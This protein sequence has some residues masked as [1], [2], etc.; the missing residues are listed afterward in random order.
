M[1]KIEKMVKAYGKIYQKVLKAGKL[2][3]P[4]EKLIAYK[5]R[6]IK[7]YRSEQFQKHNV[8]PS[9]NTTHIYAV[10]AMC[11][12]LKRFG[13]EDRKIIETVNAGFEKRRNFFKRLIACVN[14][15]PNSFDITR[16]WNISD[17]E[18][19][20]KDGSITYDYFSVSKDKVSYHIS[21]CVYVDMF[22]SYGIRGL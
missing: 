7:M 2:D 22:E 18:K 3:W 10:I 11:L 15:L 1:P 20:V 21:K 5:K 13:F 9:T 4:E 6:L 12:E 17:H 16:K 14:L 19:R 8:Y